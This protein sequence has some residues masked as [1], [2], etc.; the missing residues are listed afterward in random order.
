[1]APS[2][3]VQ[4]PGK[5][6]ADVSSS[7]DSKV[8]LRRAT[9]AEL[10]L[11]SSFDPATWRRPLCLRAWATSKDVATPFDVGGRCD[12]GRVIA[13]W[14]A[15][16]PGCALDLLASD[17]QVDT[18]VLG[19]SASDSRAELDST[20]TVLDPEAV[21]RAWKRLDPSFKDPDSFKVVEEFFPFGTATRTSRSFLR[22]QLQEADDIGDEVFVVPPQAI[23]AQE[24]RAHPVQPGFDGSHTLFR[25]SGFWEKFLPSSSGRLASILP[26]SG[27]FL[28]MHLTGVRVLHTSSILPDFSMRC[29]RGCV[30]TKTFAPCFLPCTPWSQTWRVC[31][32]EEHCRDAS[33]GLWGWVFRLKHSVL[34]VHLQPQA[35]DLHGRDEHSADLMYVDKNA[36]IGVGWRR[37]GFRESFNEAPRALHSFATDLSIHEFWD[38]VMTT[39]AFSEAQERSNCQHFVSEVLSELASRGHINAD[40]F[41]E[42]GF[43]LRNQ[44]IADVLRSWGYLDE[45]CKAQPGQDVQRQAWRLFMSWDCKAGAA[46]FL[47]PWMQKFALRAATMT[48]TNGDLLEEG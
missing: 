13:T 23:E 9:V 8:A 21:L 45:G 7:G 35:A 30:D 47:T 36:D 48:A 29:L 40:A 37:T 28:P 15:H 43:T 16:A 4:A 34:A 17:G 42:N 25:P 10:R 32:V 26:N 14:Q 12:I 18:T 31:C 1:M 2:R 3:G 22:V 5:S 19:S 46:Q 44:G 33:L 38:S 27:N 41:A 20:C 24:E 6:S 11:G 39:K